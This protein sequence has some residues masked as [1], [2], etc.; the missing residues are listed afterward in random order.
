MEFT[1]AQAAIVTQDH[2]PL[3]ARHFVRLAE[4]GRLHVVRFGPRPQ[5][6]DVVVEAPTSDVHTGPR[7]RKGQK[8]P[9]FAPVLSPVS[10]H[11]TLDHATLHIGMSSLMFTSKH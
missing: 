7:L 6:R 8:S 5:D 10:V 9:V 3:R 1:Q 4:V 11:G 2:R